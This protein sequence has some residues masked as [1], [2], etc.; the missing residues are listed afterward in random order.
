M[1]CLSRGLG[2]AHL[3]ETG[4]ISIHSLSLTGLKECVFRSSMLSKLALPNM[5]YKIKSSRCRAVWACL[6]S[7]SEVCLSI[8]VFAHNICFRI[9]VWKV[10]FQP[11][12]LIQPRLGSFPNVH[13]GY[14]WRAGP[15]WG[16]LLISSAAMLASSAVEAVVAGRPPSSSPSSSSFLG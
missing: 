4:F 16:W 2:L 5:A 13:A 6:L 11:Y 1:Q 12:I 10:V 7:H 3:W 15:H 14:F 8:P 9:S